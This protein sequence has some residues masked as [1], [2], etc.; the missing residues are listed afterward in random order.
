[1]IIA[2]AIVVTSYIDM[3]CD[4]ARAIVVTSSDVAHNSVVASYIDVI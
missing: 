1:V 3:S 2:N 4:I